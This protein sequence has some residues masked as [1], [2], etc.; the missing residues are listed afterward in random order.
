MVSISSTSQ[1]IILRSPLYH[2]RVIIE[3]VDC[4][5]NRFGKGITRTIGDGNINVMSFSGF[6]IQTGTG[7]NF[8]LAAID[9]KIVIIGNAV[10]K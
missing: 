7:F 4:Q 8:D 3:V 2:I 10:R 6:K 9:F 1:I 5:R